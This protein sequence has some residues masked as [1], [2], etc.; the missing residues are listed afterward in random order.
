MYIQYTYIYI[1][2]RIYIY[3][4]TY[5]THIHIYISNMYDT[6]LTFHLLNIRPSL[7]RILCAEIPP[8]PPGREARRPTPPG[9]RGSACCGR[10]Y[11]SLLGGYGDRN[12]SW[13]I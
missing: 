4:Y 10:V 11:L 6:E 7:G 9:G 3:I 8:T 5:D 1:Y 2:I 12:Y 13:D